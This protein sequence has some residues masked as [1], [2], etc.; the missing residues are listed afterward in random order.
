MKTLNLIGVRSEILNVITM[1]LLVFT[2]LTIIHLLVKNKDNIG[3]LVWL[4]II[5]FLPFVGP[6]SYWLKT[7]A[8]KK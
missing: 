8:N 3:K 6:T 7:L 4:L 2:L 1:L 5:I